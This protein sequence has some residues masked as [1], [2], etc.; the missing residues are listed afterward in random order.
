[1]SLNEAKILLRGGQFVAWVASDFEQAQEKWLE[2][3]AAYTSA[4]EPAKQHSA[5][6]DLSGHPDP[7]PIALQVVSSVEEMGYGVR[8][9]LAHTKWLASLGAKL[10]AHHEP[11][12]D[13]A[14]FLW[15]LSIRHLPISLEAKERF[16][17][18]GYTTVGQ[19]TELR[20]SSLRE[21]FGEESH[22]IYQ[23]IWGGKY[24]PIAA[25]YPKDSLTEQLYFDNPI[26][27]LEV[28]DRALRL[29]A[30][31]IGKRLRD[32]DLCGQDAQIY[33]DTEKGVRSYKRTFNKPIEGPRSAYGALS[34]TVP[35]VEEAVSG[36]RVRLTNL[37]KAVVLQKAFDGQTDSQ[38]AAEKALY[39]V[40]RVYGDKIIQKGSEIQSDRR[41]LLLREWRSATGWR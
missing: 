17:M 18:L 5:F 12:Q 24:E 15:P 21:Q 39:A 34:L 7:L 20:L 2:V 4:L 25:L 29:T 35:K 14:E 13:S 37:S 3:A 30:N 38:P 16:Q 31:R 19:I 40:R 36:L 9:S 1:M 26:D 33:L 41:S 11:M 10:N 27:D 22:T 23:L 6:L 28:F 32:S 8:W